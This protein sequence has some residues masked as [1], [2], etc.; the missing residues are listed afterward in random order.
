MPHR[1][2]SLRF[3]FTVWGVATFVIIEAT[4]ALV[5]FL[6]QRRA[7]ESGF[8]ARLQSRATAASKRLAREL[9][10]VSPTRLQ[11]ILGEQTGAGVMEGIGLVIYDEQARPTAWTVDPPEAVLLVQKA[12]ASNRP[13][14]TQLALDPAHAPEPHVQ[15]WRVAIVPAAGINGRPCAVMMIAGDSYAQGQQQL[16]R[17][18]VL[19]SIVLGLLA[20]VGLAWL[21]A[22]IAVAPLRALRQAVNKLAPD[23]LGA[24][25]P[26]I[27]RTREG[28]QLAEQLDGIRKR[29]EMAF[30]TQERF[31]ANVSHELKTPIA[32]V[33]TECQTLAAEGASPAVRAFIRSIEEE[34]RRLG[35]LVESFLTLTRVRAGKSAVRMRPCLLNELVMESMK[36]CW[37]M[38]REHGVSLNP[39]LLDETNVDLKVEGEPEL[40]RTMIDNLVR[41]AIRFNPKGERVTISAERTNDAVEVIVRDCGPGIPPGEIERIFDRF[42]QGSDEARRGRGHGLGLEIARG[43]AE[44]HGGTITAANHPQG[45]CVFRARLPIVQPGAPKPA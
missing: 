43:I 30:A 41:N 21:L 18:T 26:S 7:I 1:Y 35:R 39:M 27:G 20:G 42:T 17:R 2:R 31:M 38:A 9:P 34:M 45:G 19:W 23:Q 14:F 4:L 44:L 8:N 36:N 29:L 24:P 37:S 22:G 11:V 13:V 40:L 6:Y 32:T 28:E 25:M 5:F 12:L 3:K 33:L 16:L 10:N 15:V